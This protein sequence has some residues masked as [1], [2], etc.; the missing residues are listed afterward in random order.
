MA[1]NHYALQLV[2]PAQKHFGAVFPEE[3]PL[4]EVLLKSR[5]ASK[6]VCDMSESLQFTG[7]W[8]K[9]ENVIRGE[10]HSNYGLVTTPVLALV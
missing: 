9:H 4:G 7:I 10:I 1:K 2:L 6:V 8:G 3:E 5:R